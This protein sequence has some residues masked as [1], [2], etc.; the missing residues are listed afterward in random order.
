MSYGYEC[1]VKLYAWQPF[2]TRQAGIPRPLS[3]KYSMELL[4]V[5]VGFE[6][7]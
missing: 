3:T 6:Y 5:L 4:G 7:P 2:L 1:R